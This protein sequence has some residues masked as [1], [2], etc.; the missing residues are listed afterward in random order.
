[1]EQSAPA[2]VSSIAETQKI[3]A[4]IFANPHSAE[5]IAALTVLERLIIALHRAGAGPI[6]VV[7]PGLL[8]ELRRAKAL[9]ISVEVA[10]S[11]P[12]L[13][14]PTLLAAGNI[15]VQT[16]DIKRILQSGSRLMQNGLPLPIGIVHTTSAL[17]AHHNIAIVL[18]NPATIEAE[19]ARL[20]ENKS[21]ALEAQ[22][23]LWSSLTGAADGFVD[24]HF[25]RPVGRLLS[26]LLIH[27][28]VSPNAVSISSIIIGVISALF[29]AEGSYKS[30]LLG[31]ILFQLSAII[32]CVDGDLARILFKES[33]LG[34]WIDFWGDQ[35]VH[36]SVFA[37]IAFGVLR[38]GGDKETVWLGLSAIIGALLACI[39]VVRGMR[40]AAD[41]NGPLQKLINAA[42]NRDFSVLVLTLAIAQKLPW[43]LWLAAIGS[44]FFWLTALVL[45]LTHKPTPPAR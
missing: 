31:A 3:P 1:M 6:T 16:A 39:V 28:P 18:E 22:R 37:G 5:K 14:G 8:P 44:H 45:Q 15:L 11:A 23:A 12:H 25:N 36:V 7:T 4:V 40:Q 38:N 20:I 41:S 34:K 17:A 9:R 35:I 27:T 33:P 2:R 43:F 13:E 21:E 32:D 30:A 26:K 42:T 29:F 19:G 10:P 24:R